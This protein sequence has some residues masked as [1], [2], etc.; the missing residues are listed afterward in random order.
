MD[1]KSSA[2]HSSAMKRYMV[3]MREND[4]AWSEV[5]A[6]EQQRILERY[7]DWIDQ[8]TERGCYEGGE[9]LA[10]G[11]HRWR[12]VDG[13][14]TDGPFTETKEVLTGVFIV[15]AA[16]VAEAMDITQTC[17]AL[18]HGLSIELRE[19]VEYTR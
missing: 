7:F 14:I 17:P 11:G 15:R 2:R 16:T 5:S 4:G 6:D 13:A 10:P 1:T 9:A 8:L 18:S 3:I 19:I 12:V